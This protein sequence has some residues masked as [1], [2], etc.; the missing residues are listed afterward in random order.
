MKP[1]A[2]QPLQGTGFGKPATAPVATNVTSPTLVKN[3]GNLVQMDRGLAAT[4]ADGNLNTFTFV[5]IPANG[6]LYT[7][8]AAISQFIQVTAGMT[9]SAN[10]AQ[11]I[12]FATT[13][14]VG[15]RSFTFRATDTNNEVSNTATYSF[16]VVNNL[17]PEARDYTNPT[18]IGNG[19]LQ[20]LRDP[21]AWRQIDTDGSI[22]SFRF[23]QLPDA[24]TG[25]LF[26]NGAAAATGQNYTYSAAT[27]L[28][29]R[30]AAGY[31]GTD[32]IASFVT[33]DNSG[34]TSTNTG[35][36]GIPVNKAT[37][38]QASVF[39]FTTRTD[40]ENWKTNRTA[41]VT[42]SSVTIS[43]NLNGVSGYSSTAAAGETQFTVDY[44]AAS[45]GYALDWFTDYTSTANTTSTANFYFNRALNN[46]SFTMGDLDKGTAAEGSAFIDDVTFNGYRADGT[47]VRLDAGD[48]SLAPNGNNFF[49]G[50]NRI[51][52]RTNPATGTGGT[53]GPDGNVTI[54]FT[55][56]IVRLE[57]IYK[58]LQT[59]IANPGT[60]A[61][62]ISA[63]TWC[64]QADVATTI[65]GPTYANFNTLVTYTATTTNLSGLDAAHNVVPTIQLPPFSNGVS[66]TNGTYVA[67]TGIVTF[68]TT[69]LLASGAS[70]TNKVSFFM[71]NS[72]VTGTARNTADTSD[73]VAGNN[74]GTTPAAQITTVVNAAPTAVNVTTGALTIN[75]TDN[76]IEPLQGTDPQG[77]ATVASFT[78]LSLPGNGTLKLNGAN[79]T[80]NQVIA[81]AD[82]G[83]LTFSPNGTTGNRTFTYKA[84][85]DLTLT[86]SN[87]A[88]Y[89]IPVVSTIA[90]PSDFSVT[91]RPT[92]GPYRVGQTVTYTV[93]AS[94]SAVGAGV[95]VDYLLPT[96]LTFVSAAAPT[97]TTYNSGT[98]VW[99]IGAM[100][101]GS[102]QTLTVTARV[103]QTGDLTTTANIGSTT[104]PDRNNSNNTA[105][106][107]I[108]TANNGTYSEDFEG[109]IADF[110]AATVGD[111]TITENSLTG[112]ESLSA[113]VPANVTTS[114]TTPFLNLTGG[115][116]SFNLK[117]NTVQNNQNRP[118][119]IINYIN[120]AGTTVASVT[121][122]DITSTNAF[123]VS[124]PYTVTGNLKVQIV[125]VNTRGTTVF[126]VDDLVITNATTAAKSDCSANVVPTVADVTN[127]RMSDQY[128]PTSIS[129]LSGSDSDGSIASFLITSI[130]D[131]SQGVLSLNGV[132]VTAGQELTPT[133]AGQLKFDPVAGYAGNAAFGYQ[134]YDNSGA[135]SSNSATFTIP[136]FITAAVSGTIFDDV[137]YGGGAGRTYEDANNS[138][139]AS[140]FAANAIGR[141]GVTV[142]LYD[143]TGVL[144]ATTTTTTGGLYSFP[145]VFSGNYTVRVVNSG[146]TSVRTASGAVVPVQTFRTGVTDKVGGEVP[147][148]TDAA[149]NNGSQNLSAL[150]SGSFAPQ[151]VAAVVVPNRNVT[152]QIN[153]FGFNFDAVVNTNDSGP[154]SLR[155]FITNSNRL[156]NGKLAQQGLTAA[157]ESAVFMLSDGR[158]TGTAVPGIRL[159]TAA[160]AGYDATNK[161]FTFSPSSSLPAITDANTTIDGKVQSNLTGETAA[162][163]AT[164]TGPE[165]VIDFGF[166]AGVSGL[167]VNAG[168]TRIASIGLL[169]AKGGSL[170]TAGG[171]ASDGSAVTFNGAA[172]TG[173]VLTDVTSSG[174]AIA[175]VLL[176]GGATGITVS[177]NLLLSARSSAA[178]AGT[179]AYDGNGI[180]FS[181]ASSNTIS[182]NT[183]SSN[184]GYGITFIT[185]GGIGANATNTIS[186]NTISG[187]GVGT[188]SATD[189]GISIQS[190]NNNLFSGNTITANSGDGIVAMSGTSGNRFSQNNISANNG[191]GVAGDLGI[192]LSANNTNP[193]G[194]AV[195]LNADGKTAASGANGLFNFP[196]ITQ[197][198]INNGKLLVTGYSRTGA[199]IEFFIASAD[200]TNFGEGAT[201]F[202]TA[203]ENTAADV[204]NRIGS[205]SGVV[206]NMGLNQGSQV[207]ASRFA[208]S[209][210]VTPAQAAS[211]VANKITAT[212]TLPAV[213]GGLTVGNTSEYSGVFTVSSNQPLPVELKEFAAKAVKND[214]RLSWTTASERNND[215]FTVERSIAGGD[216]VAIGTV[217]GQGS[218]TQEHSYSFTDAGVGAKYSGTVYYR[219]QQVDTDGTISTSPVRTLSFTA[220]VAG[221]FQLYPNPTTEASTL[222][223]STLPAGSYQ[224]TVVDMTGRT[225]ST[226]TCAGGLSHTLSLEQAP[227]GTYVVLVRGQGLKI[228]KTLV[229]N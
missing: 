25:A 63:F 71:P 95:T 34:N 198:T 199:L 78:I 176:T 70:V 45:P 224:V 208:F 33:I 179:I 149:A 177:N 80:L 99:N 228:T 86:S 148:L 137:N 225:I 84:T 164:S 191:N 32:A 123:P 72:T 135:L 105:V 61:V 187:N 16:Q 64:E 171:P 211:F 50:N 113:S 29:F 209:F 96:G 20:D 201:Y 46:F 190:G 130:P 68:N 161:V 178:G 12:A 144:S 133:E 109:R 67:N 210:D 183:I 100:T 120:A 147:A 119:Y 48:I 21:T 182:G 88:T 124:S 173:S 31:S 41:T 85:D 220:Q 97:G 62:Y 227:R 17:P 56:P 36:L 69:P 117:V 13:G 87:T 219:L 19:M 55:E 203:T 207:N 172:A 90:T 7:A 35:R 1:T 110:C 18:L 5:T 197:A 167:L 159:G 57:L 213:V 11:Y 162:V 108:N 52:G 44:R 101:A 118:N 8:N 121:S 184:N 200:P 102:S 98:G 23:T 37:C 206:G 155:Q 143:E 104:T 131:A 216:F 58:N 205:Y 136:V 154:G 76:P 66:V 89:T 195:T 43:N 24:A 40:G 114:Y 196:V 138:A 229:K 26:V 103:T 127:A 79:V 93:V 212:A 75:T 168:N 150:T 60:Q 194:D 107:T 54:T 139:I 28:A 188:I 186:G 156:D 30:P 2:K 9:V 112:R 174:N 73:P 134:A 59:E 189:A 222:D 169:N 153:D 226:S 215:H 132:A 141:S 38:G 83:N 111:V 166:N 185:P 49:S 223:L 91:Q 39:D 146:V 27:T 221:E 92:L 192:D 74:N 94:S 115:T 106:Q 47:I 14:A 181:N 202:A 126:T 116:T 160:A 152:A 82:A 214:A 180:L 151:S 42:N 218:T 140:G 3:D 81:A 125:F 142:E 157:K 53:F 145:I 170:S 175:S 4:D 128:G 22:S 204:D 15:A 163:S 129:A 10:Q 77:D 193:N 51:T 158:T 165:V 65:S 122:A 6:T 217:K